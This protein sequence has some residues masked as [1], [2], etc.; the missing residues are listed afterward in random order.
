MKTCHSFIDLHS[1]P[2]GRKGS[3]FIVTQG[4]AGK[5]HFGHSNLWL[6]TTR[7]IG[8]GYSGVNAT[9]RVAKIRLM[10]DGMPVP[11]AVSTTPSEVLLESDYGTMRICISE[12]FLVQFHGEDGLSLSLNAPME[13][14]HSIVKD[15]LDGTW[16]LVTCKTAVNWLFVPVTGTLEMDAPYDFRAMQN[17]YMNSVWNPDENGVVDVAVEEFDAEPVLRESFPDYRE[18]VKAVQAEFEEYL[19][20]CA[21]AFPPEYAECREK[22]AW[23]VWTHT[24]V[25]FPGSRFRHEMCIMMHQEFGHCFG[26][27]QAFQAMGNCRDP[28]FA[29]DLIQS[30]FD[31]QLP[32]G[33]IPDHIDEMEV[34]YQSFKPPL[35]GVA[36]NWLYDHADVSVIPAEDKEKLY[37]EMSLLWDFYRN[38][39]DLDHDGL[40]EYHHADE[41]GCDESTIFSAGVPVANPELAAYLVCFADAL[42]RL[43]DDLGRG[44]DAEKWSAEADALAART[45][46]KLWDGKRFTAFRAGTGA[47]VKAKP[48][49]FFTPLLMGRHLPDEVVDTVVADLFREDVNI[50]KYGVPSEALDSPY[51]EHGWSRGTI[52]TP[53]TCLV[54]MGLAACGREKEARDVA[55][56]YADTL[57][58]FG[59]YHMHDPVTGQGDDR[60][61]GVNDTQHWSAW[62]AGVFMILA[63]YLLG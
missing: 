53:T 47:P 54:A 28:R 13:A 22:A 20:R 1:A 4:P 18:S 62:T 19:G 30:V 5:D 37:G 25:P 27:Q 33:Q 49:G 38:Y 3:F 6:G 9:N 24:R 50:T 45:L 36:L 41:S 15:M 63:G 51:L 55:R 59:M 14:F 58:D 48:I 23:L 12:K 7:S 42:A 10:K 2:F 61:I 17:L 57:R 8:F 11:F 44:E 60:A 26:W 35:Y 43:A 32:S 39:R 31:Y 34:I 56:R 52:Q 40:P 29:W 16:Q 46:E 21:P